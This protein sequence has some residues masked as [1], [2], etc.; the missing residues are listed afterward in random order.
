LNNEEKAENGR[1]VQW[2]ANGKWTILKNNLVLNKISKIISARP[3]EE[4]K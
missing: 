1:V 4:N 2:S 3:G